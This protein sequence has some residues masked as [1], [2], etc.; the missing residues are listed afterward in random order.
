MTL[1]AV[2]CRQPYAA[3][4]AIGEKAIENRSRNMTYRGEIAI[5]AGRTPDLPAW[6]RL[7]ASGPVAPYTVLGAVLAV[8]DLVGCHLADQDS[9]DVCCGPYGLRTWND[10]PAHH[11][12]FANVRRLH[13][14]VE[15]RGQLGVGW[16]IPADVEHAIRQQL[17][18]TA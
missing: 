6:Q 13:T 1:P 2:T 11:L 4:I 16:P 7:M 12:V 3:L 9:T 5:H 15:C 18:P 17:S 14:P 10:R 8:A